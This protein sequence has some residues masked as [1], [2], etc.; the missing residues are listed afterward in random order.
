MK[1]KIRGLWRLDE[2]SASPLFSTKGEVPGPLQRTNII[3][4]LPHHHF[5]LAS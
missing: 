5:L 1:L 2:S 4:L 3:I